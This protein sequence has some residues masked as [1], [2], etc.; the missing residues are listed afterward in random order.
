MTNFW[1][2]LYHDFSVK[3]RTL[4]RWS[5]KP[6][7]FVLAVLLRLAEFLGFRVLST[8][9]GIRVCLVRKLRTKSRNILKF[10]RIGT[11]KF[12]NGSEIASTL[13][14]WTAGRRRK[15]IKHSVCA[16][17]SRKSGGILVYSTISVSGYISKYSLIVEIWNKKTV[18]WIVKETKKLRDDKME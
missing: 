8:L 18:S 9:T 14:L 6:L 15:L 7:S 13:R 11:K 1:S 16:T 3:V 10:C 5:T 12:A 17:Y 2:E 4:R